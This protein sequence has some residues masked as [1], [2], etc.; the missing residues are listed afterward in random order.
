MYLIGGDFGE[1][2]V[3]IV[4][5]VVGIEDVTGVV[6]ILSEIDSEFG[7]VSQIFDAEKIAGRDHLLLAARLAFDAME[8]D[9]SFAD[10]SS[11]ELTCWAAGM[12]QINKSLEKVG[13]KEGENG[14]VLFVS[15]E[16]EES[17]EQAREACLERLGID[18]ND[19]FVGVDGCEEVLSETFDLSEDR[20][21]VYP[22]EELVMEKVSLLSLEQ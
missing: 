19:D 5:G 9:R 20:L 18:G 8:R 6:D 10:D 3:S 16:D 14:V 1:R 13:V 22:I 7:T 11:I 15:G 17:V 4:G 21:E 12:R 2:Y